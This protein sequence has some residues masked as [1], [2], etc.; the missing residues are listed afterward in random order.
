MNT[1]N[2]LEIQL[3]R[4]E[5]IQAINYEL[6]ANRSLEEILHQIVNVAAELMDCEVVSLLLLDEPSNT[7]RIMVTT[8]NQDRLFNIPV[9]MESIAGAAFTGNEP[10]IIHDAQA[11]PRYFPNIAESLN[12]PS[13]ALVALPL[14]FRDRKIGV[15]EAINKVKGQCFEETDIQLLTAIATQA[16]IAIENTRQM[17]QYKQ[18]AQDEQNQ[19]Q[20]AD[21]L[22][23]ASAAVTSTLDYDQVIDRILEQVG[24]VIPNDTSNMMMVEAGNIARVLRGRGYAQFGTADTLTETTLKMDDAMGLRRMIE[25]LRPIVVP[26]V[27]QDPTWVY[28]RPEHQWIRSYIGA[29]IIV[30]DSVVGFLNVNSAI[31]DLY[32]R[33]HAE[34]LQAFA[35]HAATAIE[36]A[37]LYRQAQEEIAERIKVEDELRRHRN[38]LEELVKERTAEVH[39]LAITDSLTDVFN[40]RHFMVLGNQA[41]NQAQRYNHPLTAL[42]LD[43]DHFKKINDSYGHAVGD[44]ALRKLADQ[45]RK[46]LRS[47]DILGRYGGEEFVFL[48]PETNLQTARQSAERMLAN[49]RGLRIDTP[50]NQIGIT[51]SIGVAEWNPASQ[52]T[53][54]ALIARADEV[55]YAAKQAGRNQVLAQRENK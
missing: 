14:K 53:I 18:L 17:E 4:M 24:Q 42:M 5:R 31:P 25:T 46:D 20:M 32:N 47:T 34:R 33:T 36:N 16:T 30:R 37:R 52:K 26:D 23:H 13:H 28:S 9:P 8:L 1:L 38:H 12:Y 7:L 40:R 11:D 50:Q 48:M 2:P 54:D 39:R 29:P 6:I 27:A 22:R 55:M 51:A 10:I 44:E 49:I 15:V 21:A 45:L 41:L 19:R 3:H 43:I 35:H